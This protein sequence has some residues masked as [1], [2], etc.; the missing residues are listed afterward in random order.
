MLR[1]EIPPAC[2][3]LHT[4]FLNSHHFGV[5]QARRVNRRHWRGL[6]GL[7][8]PLSCTLC[9]RD[10]ELHFTRFGQG[11]AHLCVKNYGYGSADTTVA[12]TVVFIRT[13]AEKRAQST[14]LTR[15]LFRHP[16]VV[17]PEDIGSNAGAVSTGASSFA[18]GR[19]KQRVRVDARFTSAGA[20]LGL[21]TKFRSH[22]RSEQKQLSLYHCQNKSAFRRRRDQHTNSHRLLLRHE[23]QLHANYP[24][25]DRGEPEQSSKVRTSCCAPVRQRP[26]RT[27]LRPSAGENINR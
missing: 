2:E 17:R 21:H 3:L 19:S 4:A 6:A 18:A 23:T 16:L 13:C 24:A 11:R 5:Q 22:R 7:S 15:H 14:E 10:S 27:L 1:A 8:G 25:A 9:R 26:Q 12:N 20:S